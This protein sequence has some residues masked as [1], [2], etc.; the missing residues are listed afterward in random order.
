MSANEFSPVRSKSSRKPWP[1]CPDVVIY[2]CGECGGLYQAL[3]RLEAGGEPLCCTK[4]MTLLE[5]LEAAALE[6]EIRLDY[7]IVGGFNQ[8]AVQVFWECGRAE[9]RP[10]WIMLKT[11]TGSYIKYLNEAKKAPL[12]FPLS[13]EDAYVYCDRPVCE[14]CVFR[15][16]NGFTA[17][18]YIK[19]RAALLEMPLNRTS[20]YFKTKA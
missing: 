10:E 11:Y 6:P 1:D 12:V 2:R 7:Q 15:C 8:S 3:G 13:D 17:F 16:K 9:D 4:P 19:G 20:D 18:V 14:K 5:P